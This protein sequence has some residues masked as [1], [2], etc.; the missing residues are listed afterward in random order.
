MYFSRLN[1][2]HHVLCFQGWRHLRVRYSIDRWSTA[3]M[4]QQQ[5]SLMEEKVV[6]LSL[7][8]TA[9]VWITALFCPPRPRN[10]R[11][12]SFGS[13]WCLTV[14]FGLCGLC[15]LTLMS[16]GSSVCS[17]LGRVSEGFRF[18]GAFRRFS[19][20]TPSWLPA[21]NNKKRKKTRRNTE[22]GS[23]QTFSCV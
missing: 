19:T 22:A 1:N 15:G 12:D 8:A 5:V 17:S 21:N 14:L 4:L 6:F 13:P 11:A 16:S 18:N 20:T 3:S 7:H 23:L 2:L 9:H 10:I